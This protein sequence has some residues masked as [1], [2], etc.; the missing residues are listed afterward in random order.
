MPSAISQRSR[1]ST[2]TTTDSTSITARL[3]AI[4]STMRF[5]VG[6]G[7]SVGCGSRGGGFYVFQDRPRALLGYDIGRRVG[8]PGGDAREHRGVD[9]AQLVDSPDSQFAV[10]DA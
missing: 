9:D 7:F 3:V 1:P 5:M 8:V 10:D 2:L 6:C 4:R